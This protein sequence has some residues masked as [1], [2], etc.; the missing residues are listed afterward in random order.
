MLSYFNNINPT[1]QQILTYKVSDNHS[2]Y[3]LN[4]DEKVPDFQKNQAL[5]T[6]NNISF[7]NIIKPAE[8]TNIYNIKTEG[9]DHLDLPNVHVYKYPDTNLQVFINE[10]Y[11]LQNKDNFQSSLTLTTKDTDVSVI[12]KKLF[13]EILALT[14]KENNVD[15]DINENY[16]NFIN[17]D[18]NSRVSN[19]DKL[20]TLNKLI[21]NPSITKDQFEKCK[22]TLIK[23][24][25]SEKYQQDSSEVKFW[26]NRD[27]LKSK[28]EVIREIQNTTLED[29]YNYH[30]NA[31]KNSE[32]Q[33]FITIDKNFVNNNKNIFY[34][35]L[36]SNI[37]NKFREHSENS[38]PQLKP[39]RYSKDIKI[40]DNTNLAYLSLHYPINIE[41][42]KDKLLYRYLTLL[43][44]LR[45]SPYVAENSEG[46]KYS[47]PLEL[48]ECGLDPNS[49]AFIEFNFAPT[50]KEKID[51]TDDAI[52]V[53]KA[54]LESLYDEK[55]VASTLES[56]KDYEKQ[57]YAE[58]LNGPFDNEKIHE[59]L[60]YYGYDIFKIY[61]TID[62][63]TIKDIKN[64]IKQTFFE[65]N[66]VVK[67]NEGLNP[68]KRTTNCEV[69]GD[70]QN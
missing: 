43:E 54:I 35:I 62:S 55:S 13:I 6:M 23:Y 38:I 36:N 48:K 33:Y 63:I 16:T 29:F 8:L 40:L 58:R 41:S 14:L 34:S 24:I 12:K 53:F 28:E 10:R 70:T 11:N 31:L 22:N 46:H 50:G 20:K 9:K 49:L 2:K 60:H 21:T 4:N 67:I 39:L 32:A 59:I 5:F 15:A 56:V 64:A 61:E 17:I 44:I 26:I 7:K 57:L 37:S 30:S 25:N 45:H 27:L 1:Q 18:F 68:Y 69:K 47:L 52:T 42:G 51:S 65:Q 3:Y 66:P 19:I